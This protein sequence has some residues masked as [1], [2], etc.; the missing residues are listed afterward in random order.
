MSES[1]TDKAL[2]AE[3]RTEEA[4]SLVRRARTATRRKYNCCW[5]S[6]ACTLSPV[7]CLGENLVLVQRQ[8]F[9]GSHEEIVPNRPTTSN[10]PV[11]I[12]VVK[13]SLSGRYERYIAL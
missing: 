2:A 10:H 13:I 3:E 9:W 8:G 11:G 7:G 5:F 4:R 12:N 1:D 6:T